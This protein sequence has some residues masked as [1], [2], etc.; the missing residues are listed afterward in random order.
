[1]NI[2]MALWLLCLI[3]LPTPAPA[4]NP[5]A[6]EKETRPGPRQ[7][8]PVRD[9]NIPSDAT[10]IAKD[11]AFTGPDEIAAGWITTELVNAG[12]DLHQ[13]Q[14]LKLPEGRSIQD[15]AAEIT[16][17]YKRLPH[18]V[19]RQGGPNSVIPGEHATATVHLDPGNYVVIC[20]IPDRRGVPH[21]ALGM[22]KPL[23]ITT[24][25]Q[26][27]PDPP[28]GD[29]T[30]TEEDFSFQVSK[31]IRTGRRTVRVVNNGSQ[32][33]E[34]VVVQLARRATVN[35]FLDDFQPGVV[36]SPFGKPVGGMVG[37]EPGGEG[38]FTIDFTPGRYGLICFLPDLTRGA[39]HFTRGMLLDINVD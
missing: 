22:L 17:N 18:W 32:A 2:R 14:F 8:N 33:H 23:R 4:E 11:Y 37:L 3:F 20:G 30:I 21:V 6:G 35:A 28:H 38:F 19:H 1:M 27:M 10:Y 16:A 12:D 5:S 34:V 39:P 24:G 7:Q 36:T 29:V 15:F 31:P 9:Q 13:M 25:L 26:K